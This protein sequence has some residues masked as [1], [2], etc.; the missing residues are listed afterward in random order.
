MISILIP[1]MNEIESLNQTLEIIN[2][3]NFSETLEFI[4]ILSPNSKKSAYENALAHEKD[5]IRV[6]IQKYPGL[7]GAYRHGIEISQGEYILILASDLE[8]NPYYVKD[9]ITESR[10]YPMSIIATTRWKGDG[11]GFQDYGRL[12]LALNWIFQK[13]AALLFK[14]NLT[15]FTFGYRLYPSPSIKDVRWQC[16]NF[17]FLLEAILIPITRGWKTREIP[18]KWTP[19]NEDLSNNKKIYFIEYFK[20]LFSVRFSSD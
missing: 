9:L 17:G 5:F 3:E 11:S 4:I 6:I 2:S 7:G 19:R 18:V 20:V 12:K 16:N 14:S 1:V 10:K 8:T 15:D 13:I